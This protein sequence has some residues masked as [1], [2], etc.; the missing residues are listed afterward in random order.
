M[1]FIKNKIILT[2][3]AIIVIIG[4]VIAV[5]SFSG[6]QKQAEVVNQSNQNQVVDEDQAT[7][8]QVNMN[9]DLNQATS[10]PT[11]EAKNFSHLVTLETSLGVIKFKTYDADAPKTVS[12][13]I[14]LASKNFYDNL[15][16]HRVINKFMIQG[17]DP[18]GTGAGGPGYQFADELNP[19]TESYKVGYVK[20]AVAMANAGPNTNGSQFFIMV[21]NVPLSH[22]YS[23][24][25]QVVEGQDVADAISMV[26]T[27][28]G[29]RPV[30]EVKI[31]KV[32]VEEVK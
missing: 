29:D 17:G 2:I 8:D 14:T 4:G 9:Q 27:S 15:I 7:N 30:E 21:D 11:I 18:T 10:S 24:F 1:N 32:T 26:K 25:G 20:G 23:I 22:D 16:F 6:E 28:A 5:R 13:F 31:K 3:V 19:E 12:N